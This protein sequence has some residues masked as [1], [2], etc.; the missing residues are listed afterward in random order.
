MEE[1]QAAR[2]WVLLW[3]LLGT[4]AAVFAFQW[5]APGELR[6]WASI[7]GRMVMAAGLC[8]LLTDLLFLNVKYV[9]FTGETGRE[10]PNL[11]FTVLKY[12]TF[13]PLVVPLPLAVSPWIEAGWWHALLAAAAIAGMHLLLE[14]QHRVVIADHCNQVHLEDDEEEFPMRLGLRY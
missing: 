1:L 13:L 12:F 9:A 6:G 8:L 10:Q 2:T 11:A 5:I 7:A 14:R 4:F 3:A